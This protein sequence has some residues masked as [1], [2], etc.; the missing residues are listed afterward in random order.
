MKLVIETTG[1]LLAVLAALQSRPSWSG[2]DLARQL[3]VTVRT[4]RRDVERLR[5]LGYPVESDTGARGGYRLGT[6]GAV[7]PPL[8]LD[9]DEVF[10]LAVLAHA[11]D[12]PGLGEAAERAVRKLEQM[13]PAPLQRDIALTATVV[14]VDSPT[15]DHPDGSVLRIVSAACRASDELAVRYR[16]RNG[17]VSDRRLLPYR[18]VSIGRRWYLVARDARKPDWRTWRVDRIE[19]AAPSGHRFVVGDPPDAA[20]LV[21]RSISTSPYRYHAR[22]ELDA[23]IGEIAERVPPSVAVLEAL[24]ERT[25]LLTTGSDN[26]DSIVFHIGMLDV[27]FRVLEPTEL[28]ER[29]HAL[30]ARLTR[31]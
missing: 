4:V 7:I 9:A 20:A 24:D 8:M 5:Q 12:R 30:A 14:R 16:D 6:G 22:V 18:V 26:L 2:P 15:G 1:R 25:T 19:S 11:T 13:L 28:R 21:Q 17:A 31:N 10:A 23:P 27:D 3:D 29:M